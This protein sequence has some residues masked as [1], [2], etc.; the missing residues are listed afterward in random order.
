[1]INRSKPAF[2][3]VV[4]CYWRRCGP[5]T[6]VPNTPRM[7][8]LAFRGVCRSPLPR[9]CQVFDDRHPFKPLFSALSSRFVNNT[10][11]HARANLYS[12][13]LRLLSNRKATMFGPS[14]LLRSVSV[15]P[16]LWTWHADDSKHRSDYLFSF[17]K[18]IDRGLTM[19]VNCLALSTLCRVQLSYTCALSVASLVSHIQRLWSLG[20]LVHSYCMTAILFDMQPHDS[21]DPPWR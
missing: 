5:I 6:N 10:S 19:R 9:S 4:V 12:I 15:L 2:E 18:L 1:M 7:F 17:V 8:E 16:K 20:V 14:S 21:I 11:L 13:T 3:F